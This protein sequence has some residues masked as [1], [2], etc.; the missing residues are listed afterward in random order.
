MRTPFIA[1]NWKMHKTIDEAVALVKELRSALQGVVGCDVAIC[2]PAPSLAHLPHKDRQPGGEA[3]R[4]HSLGRDPSS[5]SSSPP[6][7][8]QAKIRHE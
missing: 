6:G 2:P 5:L 7:I 8:R 3:Q 1:G 4:H